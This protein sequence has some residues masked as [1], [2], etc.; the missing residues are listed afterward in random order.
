VSTQPLRVVLAAHARSGSNSLVEILNLTP[1]VT[2]LNEP[3]NENFTRWSSENPNYQDRVVDVESLDDVMDDIFAAW[4]GIKILGY[5][6]QLP[7]FEHLLLRPDVRVIFLRRRN[8]LETVVSNLIALQTNLWKTWDADGPIEPRYQALD[9]IPVKEVQDLL[10]WTRTRLDETQEILEQR[11]DGQVLK[12]A[13]EDLYL[14]TRGPQ[15]RLLA[16][17]WDFL[18]T[19]A[20]EDPRIGY[21][22]DP[23]EVQMAAEATYGRLPNAAEINEACGSP[24]DGWLTYL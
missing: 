2:I 14:T 24:E 20:S 13:Y 10:H 19:P 4:T 9:P 6:L 3:F 1:G 16:Q 12:L 7:L 11:S 22:L 18:G 15:D 17:L 8:L 23:A 5:Q 21:Y